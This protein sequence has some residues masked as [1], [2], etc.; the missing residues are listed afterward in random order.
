MKTYKEV[1]MREGHIAL[2]SGFSGNDSE[3]DYKRISMIAY[4]FGKSESVVYRDVIKSRDS[5][6]TYERVSGR[7]AA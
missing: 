4:I 2:S 3:P 5:R 6:E 7:K 1:I